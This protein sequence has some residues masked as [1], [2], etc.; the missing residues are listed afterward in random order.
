[1][2]N[3]VKFFVTKRLINIY[4]NC[5]MEHQIPAY[6]LQNCIII[7]VKGAVHYFLKDCRSFHLSIK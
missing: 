5:E 3:V 4:F 1:M 7:F 6:R 2:Y